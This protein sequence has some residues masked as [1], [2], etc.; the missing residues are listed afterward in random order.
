MYCRTCALLAF[1]AGYLLLAAFAIADYGSPY[2]LAYTFCPFPLGL[3]IGLYSEMAI[4]RSTDPCCAHMLEIGRARRDWAPETWVKP[5]AAS[6]RVG[7]G[8]PGGQDAEGGNE[9]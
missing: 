7:L 2:A 6:Q 9:L 5:L 4:S 8:L 1:L 3:L